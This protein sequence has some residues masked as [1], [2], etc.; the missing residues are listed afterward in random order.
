[1]KQSRQAREAQKRSRQEKAKERKK[2]AV[3]E[4]SEKKVLVEDTPALDTY[5]ARQRARLLLGGLVTS[6]F[7]IFG[8][9]IYRLFIHDP[10]AIEADRR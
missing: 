1:M 9:V 8:Y 5:E 6:C 7:L 3:A 2:P 10:M 4:E